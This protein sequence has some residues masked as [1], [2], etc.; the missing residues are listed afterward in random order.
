MRHDTFYE[1]FNK[2]KEVC[3][4]NYLVYMNIKCIPET[5]TWLE[6]LLMFVQ[7]NDVLA[8]SPQI[9]F[10][11]NKV[12]FAGAALDK[13]N[14][15]KIHMMNYKIHRNS[16][17]YEANMKHVR[18]VTLVTPLC[19]MISKDKLVELSGFDIDMGSYSGVD[20]CLRGRQMKYWNIWTC[21]S[22]IYY[23]GKDSIYSNFVYNEKFEKKWKTKIEMDDE[24]YHPFLKITGKV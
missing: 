10:R 11:K 7:R 20:L 14:K 19:M 12:Y 17:G 5:L 23:D 6:E 2:A 18:N 16:E 22:Q 24:Y 4:G 21:F 8:A 15:T 1:W 9:N 3:F 13:N